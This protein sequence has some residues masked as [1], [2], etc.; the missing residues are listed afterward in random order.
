MTWWE[1]LTMNF[2]GIRSTKSIAGALKSKRWGKEKIIRP[3]RSLQVFSIALVLLPAYVWMWILKLLLE[4]TFPFLVFLFG[5]FMMSFIIYLIL[6]NSFFNKR[7]IYTIRVNRDAI[8]IRKNKFYWRDI[9]ETCI[10]YKYEGRTM[11]KYL[12]IFRKDEIVEKFDLYKFS[13]SD[14]KLSEIIEYYKANN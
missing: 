11:N 3:S 4:Y 8:S 5:F 6:R 9:V 14:K 2:P 10:M 1:K 13:I 7:Y 12:L